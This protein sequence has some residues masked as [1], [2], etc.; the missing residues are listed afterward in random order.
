MQARDTRPPVQAG[1][2]FYFRFTTKC[3]H[4]RITFFQNLLLSLPPHKQKRAGVWLPP[5]LAVSRYNAPKRRS[6]GQTPLSRHAKIAIGQTVA[7]CDEQLMFISRRYNCLWF[8]EPV[9]S[10]LHSGYM[11]PYNGL[12]SRRL[13]S[14]PG[15][16]HLNSKVAYKWCPP[17]IAPVPGAVWV[18][19]SRS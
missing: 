4:T 14:E 11:I 2:R 5:L 6:R 13:D 3:S 18:R 15:Q 16:L 17:L 19:N 7:Q 8:C 12:M 10:C 9:K 1:R